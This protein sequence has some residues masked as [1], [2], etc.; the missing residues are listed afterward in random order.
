MA[1]KTS[2]IYVFRGLPRVSY[3]IRVRAHP[4]TPRIKKNSMTLNYILLRDPNMSGLNVEAMVPNALK[5]PTPS[6]TTL[7]GKSST[8]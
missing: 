6:P 4:I 5:A 8:V 3:K 2:S 7:V 1:Y